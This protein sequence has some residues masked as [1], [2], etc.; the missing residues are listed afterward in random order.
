M[1]VNI[2][3][4][5]KK[6]LI[7]KKKYSAFKSTKPLKDLIFESLKAFLSTIMITMKVCSS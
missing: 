1:N 3:H 4:Q 2:T 5:K 7:K 6:K